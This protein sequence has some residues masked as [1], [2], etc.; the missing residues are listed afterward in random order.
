MTDPSD[1]ITAVLSRLLPDGRGVWIPMDHG[2]SG[3]PES[4]LDR[5]M[6]SILELMNGIHI[7]EIIQ[8]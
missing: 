7:L 5:M 4:G 1:N 2:L 8:I 6:N 3:Y